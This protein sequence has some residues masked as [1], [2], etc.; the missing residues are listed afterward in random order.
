MSCSDDIDPTSGTIGTTAQSISNQVNGT[1]ILYGSQ[2]LHRPPVPI[3]TIEEQCLAS[4]T[5]GAMNDRSLE[6]KKPTAGTCEWLFQHKEWE[7]W[8]S[9]PGDLMWIKGKPGSGKSTLLRYAE[10]ELKKMGAKNNALTLSFFFHG[11]GEE[12]QR[13]PF[14]MYRSLLCQILK[15]EPA[16]LPQLVETFAC[17]QNEKH[18]S[19][20]TWKWDPNHLGNL[21]DWAIDDILGS[22]PI[23]LFIDGLDECGPE[24]A[25]EILQRLN[26]LRRPGLFICV[27]CRYDS[28]RNSDGGFQIKVEEHN[29]YDIVKYAQSQ[30]AHLESKTA[31][32]I[33]DLIATYSDG[34]FSSACLA[35]ERLRGVE[36]G[37]EARE[38][39][40]TVKQMINSAPQD[41]KSLLPQSSPATLGRFRALWHQGN[42]LPLRKRH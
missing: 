1:Q 2:Y 38:I 28:L 18:D 8:Q 10:H 6:I 27:S 15:H 29:K 30:L 21:L 35:V 4:L 16:S 33:P 40:D 39:E 31:F 3:V 37:M 5:F 22:R 7:R 14:G 11:H 19:G 20:A 25:E 24:G 34:C 13:I 9:S 26:R 32:S 41:L 23:W 12:L 42:G 36:I 17:K